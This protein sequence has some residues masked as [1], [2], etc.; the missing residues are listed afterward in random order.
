[1]STSTFARLHSGCFAA[2]AEVSGFMLNHVMNI[3]DVED[4]IIHLRDA[5]GQIAS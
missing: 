2:L 4:K 1:M 3:T 5:A